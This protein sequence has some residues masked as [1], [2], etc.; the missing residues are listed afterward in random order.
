MPVEAP[1]WRTEPNPCYREGEVFVSTRDAVA[2]AMGDTHVRRDEEHPPDGTV[3]DA[4][5]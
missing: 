2:R 5:R 4:R 3:W 1:W